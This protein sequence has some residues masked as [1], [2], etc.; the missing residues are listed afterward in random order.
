MDIAVL[1]DI[2]GNHEALKTCV[3]HALNKGI[4]TFIFLGDYTAELAY[5]EKTMKFIYNMHKKYECYFIRGNKEEYW[6]NYLAD[7][8]TGWNRR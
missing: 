2:H 6:L 8:E 7:G 1:S 4:K 5:P 3:T